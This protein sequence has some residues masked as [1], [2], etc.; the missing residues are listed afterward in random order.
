MEA[1]A[2]EMTLMMVSFTCQL[3]QG[4]H[5]LGEKLFCVSVSVFVDEINF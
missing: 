3:D 5:I 1:S 2:L 4:A